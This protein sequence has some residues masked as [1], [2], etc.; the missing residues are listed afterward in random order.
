[1]RGCF[2]VL[3]FLFNKG[4]IMSLEDMKDPTNAEGTIRSF[5]SASGSVASSTDEELMRSVPNSM[6]P[7]VIAVAKGRAMGLTADNVV[8]MPN[9]FAVGDTLYHKI[10][11]VEVKFVEEIKGKPHMCMVKA[12]S[13]RYRVKKE[14]LVKL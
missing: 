7:G 3:S 4:D 13:H 9:M 6:D 2:G 12:G 10:Q 11:K 5:S 1:M 8:R 14:N